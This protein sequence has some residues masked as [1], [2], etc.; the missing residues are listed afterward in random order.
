MS[1][2][3]CTMGNIMII[4]PEIDEPEIPIL[5]II[6]NGVWH[7]LNV[8]N[9][10]QKSSSVTASIIKSCSTGGSGSWC[11][12]AAFNRAVKGRLR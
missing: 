8:F 4:F 2:L 5:I 7:K 12:W 1:A 6:I 3:F 9:S 10:L 11:V